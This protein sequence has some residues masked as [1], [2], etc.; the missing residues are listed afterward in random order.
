MTWDVFF[1]VVF[2]L[3]FF[4]CNGD[5]GYSEKDDLTPFGGVELAQ[6]CDYWFGCS[7]TNLLEDQRAT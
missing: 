3:F 2:F 6:S 7:T 5:L 1:V 4:F